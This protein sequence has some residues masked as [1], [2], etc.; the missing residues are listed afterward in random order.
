MLV[1]LRETSVHSFQ[2]TASMLEKEE[3]VFGNAIPHS[4]LSEK[5]SQGGLEL[6]RNGLGCLIL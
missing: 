3:K 6:L 5:G 4:C 2:V 1:F